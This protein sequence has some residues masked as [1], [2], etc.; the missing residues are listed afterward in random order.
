Y[1][2]LLAADQLLHVLAA[3][4][5]QFVVKRDDLDLGLE[6][7]LIVVRRVQAGLQGLA[8]LTHHNDRGLDCGQHREQKIEKDKGIGIKR[9]GRQQAVKADPSRQDQT[10]TNNKAP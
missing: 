3:H 2:I 8:V 7:D 6:V 10:K 5:I 9:P 1:L 4:L